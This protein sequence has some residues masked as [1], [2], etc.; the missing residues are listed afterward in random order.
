MFEEKQRLTRID[1]ALA[2]KILVDRAD[3]AVPPS[4]KVRTAAIGWLRKNGETF[5]L[6][7][8]RSLR[9]D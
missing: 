6:L 8:A 9:N 3:L 5:R 7:H 1:K 4:M 2:D